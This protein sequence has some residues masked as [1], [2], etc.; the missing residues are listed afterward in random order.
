[1]RAGTLGKQLAS[2]GRREF[3]KLIEVI[4]MT[5]DS[6]VDVNLQDPEACPMTELEVKT[7]LTKL[8]S[9]PQVWL[10]QIDN[11]NE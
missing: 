10:D 7:L 5:L 1:M 6:L 8:K 11:W 9:I 4:E 3:V 2:N